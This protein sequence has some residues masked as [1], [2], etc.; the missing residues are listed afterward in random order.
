[1]IL[2][3]GAIRPDLSFQ[4]ITFEGCRNGDRGN[5]EINTSIIQKLDRI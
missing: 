2:G 1:M 5:E 4:K 3:R